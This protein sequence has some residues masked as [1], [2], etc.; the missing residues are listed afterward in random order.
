MKR[1][2]LRQILLTLTSR[3]S[4]QYWERRYRAGMTSG[5]G[6]Y[7]VLSQFKAELLNA[8]V[9]SN[10]VRTVLEFGCGDGNQLRLAAYPLY[11]GLDVS[12]TAIDRCRERFEGDD[13]K[14]FLWYDPART[15]NI[16]N[17]L[18][19]DLTLSLDVLYHLVEDDVYWR[20]LRD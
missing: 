13:T 15:I 11:L 17:F 2:T 6:S 1:T 20:Y 10:D 9:A 7:G 3:S 8:F 4:G 16:A 19:A 12:K 18:D 14:S 5:V